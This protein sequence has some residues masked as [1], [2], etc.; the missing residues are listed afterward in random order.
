MKRYN[1]T[2]LRTQDS[3]FGN[4]VIRLFPD[5]A[6]PNTPNTVLPDT[7]QNEQHSQPIVP[8]GLAV[9]TP[10]GE[11]I[12]AKS[13]TNLYFL[14]IFWGDSRM[15]S[16][17]NLTDQRFAFKLLE[18]GDVGSIEMLPRTAWRFM[19]LG[20]PPYS[21]EA[22]ITCFP[23]ILNAYTTGKIFESCKILNIPNPQRVA[24]AVFEI[25]YADYLGCYGEKSRKEASSETNT[26]YVSLSQKLVSLK[27]QYDKISQEIK[28][29][30][31]TLARDGR[32]TANK[33]KEKE[34]KRIDQ[35]LAAAKDK[36]KS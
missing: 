22:V 8:H 10:T 13:P 28:K 27:E 17:P 5:K 30:E 7:A 31:D 9:K 16:L 15:R 11:K 14:E 3:I 25:I 6:Q 29:I 18:Q 32:V 24:S 33:M 2:H 34:R 23:D 12:G 1:G 21:T 4:P 20:Y 19:G 36:E 26:A 35:I